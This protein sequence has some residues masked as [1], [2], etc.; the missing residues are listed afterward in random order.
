VTPERFRELTEI[1]GAEPRRWPAAERPAALAYMRDH[2]ADAEAALADAS[3]LDGMLSNYT[4]APPGA[5]LREQIAASTPK[6]RK[7]TWRPAGFWWQSAGLTGLGL[8][9]ALAGALVISAF[10]MP[11]DRQD[12]EE[13]SAYVVTAFDESS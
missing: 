9:G 6:A 12:D 7:S 1:Y 4:V 5:A 3:L 8:A 13:E 11:V 10:M 2:A